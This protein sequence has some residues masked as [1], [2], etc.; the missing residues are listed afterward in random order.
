MEY[1]KKQLFAFVFFSA[2]GFGLFLLPIDIMGEKK[3]FIAHITDMVSN[4]YLQEFNILSIACAFFVLVFTIVFIFYTSKVKFLNKLFKASKM[5]TLARIL[6]SL[7]YIIVVNGWF[8]GN[9]FF[10]IINDPH[11]GGVMVGSKGL[12]TILYCT[13]F[14]GILMIPMITH[15]GAVEYLGTLLGPFVHKVFKVPGYSAIDIATSFVGDGAIGI[16]MTDSQYMR[17]YYTTREAYIVATSFS[18]VGITFISSVAEE[19]GFANIFPFFYLTIIIS[20]SIIAMITARLPLKKYPNEY[21]DKAAKKPKEQSDGVTLHQHALEL[22]CEQV[23]KA[24][25][26]QI[27]K[28]SIASILKIFVGFLP[29]IMLVGTI[30]LVVAEKTPFFHIVSYPLIPFYQFAGFSPEAAELMAPATIVGIADMYLPSLIIDTSPSEASKFF[31]G[32]LGFTQLVFMSE[33]GM[34]LL[35]TSIGIKF[36]DVIKIFIYRT[37]LSIPIVLACTYFLTYIGIISF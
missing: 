35:K 12:I 31:I 24:N 29:I 23:H 22:A 8:E 6:G 37:I 25:L 13:F 5:H 9:A 4:N 18:I 11:I 20:V 16:V 14:V 19:L 33:T 1:D 27:T 34:G 30:A 3:I 7:L 2:V 28:E 26:K 32:T 17:G 36:F 15:F 10:D 21:Y